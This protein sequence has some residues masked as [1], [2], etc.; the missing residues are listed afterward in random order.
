MAIYLGLTDLGLFTVLSTPSLFAIASLWSIYRYRRNP[1]QEIRFFNDYFEVTGWKVNLRESYDKIENLTKF[2]KN[3]GDFSTN[4]RVSFSIG[5][6]PS[7]IV[8]PNRW[9]RKRGFDLY[10][11]LQQR[12]QVP[13]TSP[14]P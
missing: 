12:T 7:A 3:F 14:M 2:R 6:Y 5:D 10:T 1:L 11:W 8:V 13:K 9:N 4:T